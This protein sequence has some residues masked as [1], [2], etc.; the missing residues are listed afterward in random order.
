MT[1]TSERGVKS[2]PESCATAKM[3]SPFNKLGKIGRGEVWG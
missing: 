3:E 2:D 1:W